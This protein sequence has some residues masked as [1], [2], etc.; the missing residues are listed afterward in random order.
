MS[1]LLIENDNGDTFYTGPLNAGIELA[2]EDFV[3]LVKGKSSPDYFADM[4][5]TVLL[6]TD[7]T[8]NSTDDWGVG[9]TV[10]EAYRYALGACFGP[11]DSE[12]SETYLEARI[13]VN[14]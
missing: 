4:I 1:E 2:L 6:T 12:Y 5:Y 14:G 3:I 8:E 7:G 11:V 10:E 9:S 13:Y